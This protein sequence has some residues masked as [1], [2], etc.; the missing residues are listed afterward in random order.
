MTVLQA[1]KFHFVKGG[2]ERYYLDVSR[3]LHARGH[4]VIPFAMRHVRNEPS[5]YERYFV[6]EVDYRG[7]QSALDKLRAASRSV[8]SRETVRQI[9]ALVDHERPQIAH[10]HNIYHQISPA[11][12]RAL[13]RLGVPMVHTLHDYK[14]VCPG[15]LFMAGGR[16]CECCRGGRYYRAVTH[17]CL[18]DSRA[19]SLVGAVEAYVHR[20]LRT[21]EKVRFFL[22]P[23]WF[24]L[25]KVAQYGVA[26]RRLVHFP[27]FLPLEEYRPSF[28]R[29]DYF[30]YLGRLS[31]EKG[32]PTLLAAL[33][34]RTG[35]RLTCRILG[36]GPLEADLRRQASDWGLD[37]VEFSGYL[38]GEPLQAA[39]RGAAFTVVPS[40]WYEN[41][42]FAVLESFALGT[43]VV[44]SRIGGLPEMV[45]DGETGLTFTMGDSRALAEALDRM[46]ASPERAVEM[47]RAARRLMEVRYAP[48]P[49][50]ERLEALY[51][52][53]VAGG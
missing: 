9:E 23:S 13:D 31:R 10:L 20:W 26:R 35:T 51:A 44:G 17:R 37:R 8:Y 2:A 18:L 33:R 36:E 21:Y 25:E 45:L 43:P 29:S 28:E 42:P 50:L 4:R 16:I 53:V 3:R 38:A 24:L 6:S 49:H 32:V 30:I 40:E 7:S 1:N 22:C 41:L 34:Q 46:E 52:R 11:L 5:E 27:Y 14:I 15:Y 48:E 39:I 12:V 19:A 47:G